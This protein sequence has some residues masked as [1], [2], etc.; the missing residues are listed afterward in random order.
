MTR[1]SFLLLEPDKSVRNSKVEFVKLYMNSRR[2]KS[3]QVRSGRIL[4]PHRANTH[5]QVP[6]QKTE[7][8]VGLAGR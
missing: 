3:G 1:W 2:V 4:H 6:I 8:Q 5:L 7:E